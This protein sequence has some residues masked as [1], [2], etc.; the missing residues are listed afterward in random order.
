[1]SKRYE[2]FHKVT[3]RQK[4]IIIENDFTFSKIISIVQNH[5]PLNKKIL[6]IGCGTGSLDIYLASR[7]NSVT[8]VD[9][10][11]R[12]IGACIRDAKT[13][14]V[15]GSAKFYVK[16]IGKDRISGKFDTV[17]CLEVIEHVRNDQG[18]LRK[19]RGLLK[20]NG[21][22]I[23]STPSLNAPLYKIGFLDKFDERVGHLRRYTPKGI[24]KKI[25]D[26]GFIIVESRKT[27]GVLRNLLFT[28]NAGSLILKIINRLNLGPYVT[29]IDKVSIKLFGESNLIVVARKK[30]DT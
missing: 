18:L 7:G 25:K 28:A 10:S 12:A 20:T 27:E 11:K 26:L 2:K 16:D 22:L 15:S 3:K 8:G 4:K 13:L 6:D 30:R 5:K 23:L 17:L 14:G 21:L 19:I 29:S 24:T 1:M 9:I